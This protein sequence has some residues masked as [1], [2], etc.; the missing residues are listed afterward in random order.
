MAAYLPKETIVLASPGFKATSVSLP[1]LTSRIVDLSVN[2]DDRI[3]I[4]LLSN[5]AFMG[6]DAEGLPSPAFAGEDGTYHIPG[7]LSVAPPQAIKKI[8]GHCEKIGKACGKANLVVL[9][10][11][12]PRY[13]AKKCC[14]DPT[15]T[16]N[17]SCDDFELEI[18]SGIGTHKRLLESWAQEHSMNYVLVDV[19]ELSDP[20][21]PVLRNRT[22]R[23]G[24]PLWS[25]WDPVHL[26]PEAYKELADYV[27]TAGEPDTSEAGS[28]SAS[29]VSNV[30]FGKRLPE[31]VITVPEPPAAKRGRNALGAKPAGWLSGQA[32]PCIYRPLHWSAGHERG[33]NGTGRRPWVRR[34]ARGD[35]GARRGNGGGGWRW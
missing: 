21:E 19:T 10:A 30:S 25:N 12:I 1:S 32:D 4:D 8:L 6:T 34:G 29:S 31:S 23:E 3:V 26:A 27:L 20:A 33:R 28:E 18:V 9:V 24:V 2:A 35:R 13:V 16:E 11:P 7:S 15:H 14:E 5:S 22:T 17:F